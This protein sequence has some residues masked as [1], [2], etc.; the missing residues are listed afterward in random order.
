M[1]FFFF[2]SRNQ[3]LYA[4]FLGFL[5]RAV[6]PATPPPPEGAALPRPRLISLWGWPV[7]WGTMC[8]VLGASPAAVNGCL[9]LYLGARCT[10]LES[11]WSI[12]DI[13][14]D[15]RNSL[16]FTTVIKQFPL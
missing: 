6:L 1:D 4:A 8:N 16:R 5:G 9:F 14:A 12:M 7:V 2:V 13:N 10:H 11:T 15:V 3:P